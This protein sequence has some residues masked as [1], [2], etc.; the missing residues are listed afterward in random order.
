[1]S[2]KKIFKDLQAKLYLR[3]ISFYLRQ[4]L[5]FYSINRYFLENNSIRMIESYLWQ[6]NKLFKNDRFN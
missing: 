2:I 4:Y 6:Q 3:L 1:V 5:E